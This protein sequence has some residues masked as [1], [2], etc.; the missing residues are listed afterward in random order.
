MAVGK[1]FTVTAVTVTES[2][3]RFLIDLRREVLA[4]HII[5][6]LV[7]PTGQ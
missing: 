3:N 5:D 4:S 6:D 2:E 7:A 1:G